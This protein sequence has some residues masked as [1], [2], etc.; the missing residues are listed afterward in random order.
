LTNVKEC[1]QRTNPRNSDTD[2]DGLLDYEE[3]YVYN[4][5]PLKIDSDEDGLND[6]DELTYKMDP[7]NPITLDDGIL[8]GD[9]VFSVTLNGEI[10]DDG[11]FAPSLDI[12][13]QGKQLSSL[14]IK[15]IDNSD[16]FMNNPISGYIGSAYDLSVDGDFSEARLSFDLSN[17]SLPN[18]ADPT[19]FF[20]MMRSKYLKRF[21][22]KQKLVMS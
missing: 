21:L 13:L 15:K 14:S 1:E 19:I 4:T 12:S 6:K 2:Y 5:D 20:G 9:R 8:D 22:I 17:Y 10:S 7:L 16:V 3:V 18:G 11:L